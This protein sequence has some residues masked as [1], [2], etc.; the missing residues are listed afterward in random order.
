MA[1]IPCWSGSCGFTHLLGQ[2]LLTTLQLLL[3]H[4]V[5]VRLSCSVRCSV[6]ADQE[7]KVLIMPWSCNASVSTSACLLTTV[8]EKQVFLVRDI[9]A[10]F[11]HSHR[12]SH[13]QFVP[14]LILKRT[15]KPV[16]T[17]G[18][19]KKTPGDNSRLDTLEEARSCI[20]LP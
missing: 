16:E 15:Q 11:I 1:V 6:C 2:T 3:F 4:Y 9:L 10:L 5:Q 12:S 7:P 17:Y 18:Q 19:N 14:S 20:R 8:S 13:L